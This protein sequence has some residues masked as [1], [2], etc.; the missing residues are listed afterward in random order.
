MIQRSVLLELEKQKAK[1]AMNQQKEKTYSNKV[2]LPVKRKSKFTNCSSRAKHDSPDDSQKDQ[3]RK[4]EKGYRKRY[5][6]T[7]MMKKQSI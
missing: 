5:V 2:K 1:L 4:Y 6:L 7:S 3:L